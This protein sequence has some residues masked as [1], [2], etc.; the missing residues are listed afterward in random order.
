MKVTLTRW[1]TGG[2]AHGS[3]RVPAGEPREESLAPVL[4]GFV[5]G[6]R[7]KAH[8]HCSTAG[9]HTDAFRVCVHTG[10]FRKENGNLKKHVYSVWFVR[11]GGHVPSCTR[12]R[13]PWGRR[14]QHSG[15]A[16]SSGAA[17]GGGGGSHGSWV[18]VPGPSVQTHFHVGTPASGTRMFSSWCGEGTFPR[19]ILG[20]AVR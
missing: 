20:R 18:V 1:S 14:D 2:P 6:L 13:A 15:R 3:Q 16:A 7:I 19:G 8:A 9:K 11:T 5:A 10:I 17:A 4:C 12:N